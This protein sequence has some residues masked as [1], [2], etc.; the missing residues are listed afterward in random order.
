[1]YWAATIARHYTAD[2]KCLTS[3]ADILILYNVHRKPGNQLYFELG[4]SPL[5]GLRLADLVFPSHV[6]MGRDVPWRLHGCAH[7]TCI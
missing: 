7:L 5:H 1:M 2:K 4:L 3:G 6:H